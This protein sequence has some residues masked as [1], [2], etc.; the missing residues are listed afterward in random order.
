M[1]DRNNSSQINFEDFTNLWKYI[2]EWQNCFR[3]FD[4]DKSG[5]IDKNEF[6]QALTTFGT[7]I[8]TFCFII[9]NF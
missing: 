2:V 9:F 3:S 7:Y 5:F 1:F 4:A 6:K 8:R